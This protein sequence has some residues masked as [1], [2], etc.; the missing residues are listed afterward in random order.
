[1]AN[2]EGADPVSNALPDALRAAALAV[3]TTTAL[4]APY[5]PQASSKFFRLYTLSTNEWTFLAPIGLS[6]SES[7]SKQ[8]EP[9]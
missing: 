7:L 4:V 6:H 3:D 5:A 8:G 2:R 1:M 9:W